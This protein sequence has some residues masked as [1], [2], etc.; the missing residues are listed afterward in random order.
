MI[1]IRRQKCVFLYLSLK[2]HFPAGCRSALCKVWGALIHSDFILKVSLTLCIHWVHHKG[3]C[4]LPGTALTLV[5]QGP[6]SEGSRHLFLSLRS[7]RP[8]FPD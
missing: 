4:I 7:R 1:S 8:A 2:L 6:L 3:F 5:P